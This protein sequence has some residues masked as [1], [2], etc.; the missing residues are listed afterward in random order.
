MPEINIPVDEVFKLSESKPLRGKCAVLYCRNANVKQRKLCWK[1]TL[2][3]YR[4][5]N[6]T[7]SAFYGIRERARRKKQDFQL[8]L[9][10]FMEIAKATGYIDG[11][12]VTPT[13]LHLDRIDPDKGYAFDNVQVITA[14]E[15]CSKGSYERWVR[16]ADGKM[17]RMCDLGK[18]EPEEDPF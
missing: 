8:T 6:P 17:V 10:Q 7:K 1:C 11:K 13:S 3:L 9:A 14:S 15:N 5:R 2:R 18:D 4:L 16:G 12:G